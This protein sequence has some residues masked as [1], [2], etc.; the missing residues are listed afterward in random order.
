M[1]LRLQADNDA[2]GS[3]GDIVGVE[4][5]D[6]ECVTNGKDLCTGLI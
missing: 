6:G 2:V 4:W 3:S 1:K 5:L